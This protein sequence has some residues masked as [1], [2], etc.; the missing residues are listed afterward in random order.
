[1]PRPPLSLHRRPPP[2]GEL[3]GASGEE[4]QLP[5]ERAQALLIHGFTSTPWEV[6][7]VGDVFSSHGIASHGLL[8][9]GHGTDPAHLDRVSRHDWVDAARAAWRG[10]DEMQPRFLVGSSM[11]GLIAIVLASELGERVDGL[12]L[13]APA[14][15]LFPTGVLG[16]AIAKLGLHRRGQAIDKTVAGGDIADPDARAQNPTYPVMPWAALAEFDRLRRDAKAVLHDVV[17]PTLVMHGANDT[18]VHPR[19]A[20]LVAERVRAPFVDRELLVRSQHIIG[21]D[22][23]R[24]HVAR[25]ALV[26]VERILAARARHAAS[27]V[28]DDDGESE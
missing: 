8:L 24:E 19:S 12:V 2:A 20:R 16:G 17:T 22:H 11:G 6:R 26:F 13:L 18:T 23:E 15:E 27:P 5:G 28:P 10:L 14:L 25:R 3:P 1:M 21:V 7:C 9:P 4:W